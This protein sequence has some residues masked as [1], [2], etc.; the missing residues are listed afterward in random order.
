VTISHHNLWAEY[1]LPAKLPLAPIADP[2]LPLVSVV[3]PSYNQGQFIRTTIESVLSQ[4]YPNIEYW[5]VDAGST[6]ATLGILREYEADP[7]FHWISERDRGQSD[8]INKGWSRCSGA[9]LAWLNSDDFY[10][11]GAI[12]AQVAFLQARPDI[13]LVYGKA[14]AV[15]GRG[16][17]LY[18][19]VS[20]PFSQDTLA[21][22]CFIPQPTVFLRRDVIARNGPVDT[23]LH[24]TMDYDYWLRASRHSRLA[25]NPAPIAAFRLHE[26]SKTISTAARFNPESERTVTRFLEADDLPDLLQRKRRQIY[27]DLFLRLAVNAA[28]AHDRANA[29]QYVRRSLSY[30]LL[31]PRLFWAVLALLDTTGRWSLWRILTNIWNRYQAKEAR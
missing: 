28:R 27:A 12:R 22:L 14:H 11:P 29:W 25:Y 24:Y 31:R 26:G 5:V 23:T 6:D 13:A 21:R 7:R 20:R 30:H 15:D 16:R 4:D 3:T 2:S 17:Y 10:L 8:A 18:E 9:I 1:P 19:I